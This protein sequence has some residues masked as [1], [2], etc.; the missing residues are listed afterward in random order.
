MS[1]RLLHLQMYSIRPM[2]SHLDY[3]I[4]K[5]NVVVCR[6]PTSNVEME[7]RTLWKINI[8]PGNNQC[9]M[10]TNLPTPIWQGS[11]LIY[12]R[13]SCTV[14]QSQVQCRTKGSPLTKVFREK[15]PTFPWKRTCPIWNLHQSSWGINLGPQLDLHHGSLLDLHHISEPP[16]CD[17]SLSPGPSTLWEHPWSVESRIVSISLDLGGEKRNMFGWSFGLSGAIRIRRSFLDEVLQMPTGSHCKMKQI[18]QES[19]LFCS[20]FEFGCTGENWCS[21]DA[22][23]RPISPIC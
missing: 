8:G 11:M 21:D 19:R 15:S 4:L 2:L 5:C 20:S 22:I 1:R 6:D 18:S 14:P 7:R 9:L 13:V 12:W 10:Q 23:W 3:H 16:T 17:W